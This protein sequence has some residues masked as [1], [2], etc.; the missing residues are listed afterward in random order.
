VMIVCTLTH[1]GQHGG[2]VKSDVCGSRVSAT[3]GNLLDLKSL[4]E[5]L[6]ISWNLV[7]APGKLYN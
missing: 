1:Q 5:I 7:D 2:W 3:P 6:E 4:L